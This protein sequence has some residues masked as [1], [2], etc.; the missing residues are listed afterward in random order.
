[1]AKGKKEEA[2]SYYC[3]QC[4]EGFLVDG[5]VLLPTRE[6][7]TK[8]CPKCKAARRRVESAGGNSQESK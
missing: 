6:D 2:V 8:D 7:H 1:M 3:S 4:G 5:S